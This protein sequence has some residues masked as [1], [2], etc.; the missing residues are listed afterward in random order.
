MQSGNAPLQ[1]GWGFVVR[2][3]VQTRFTAIAAWG[4]QGNDPAMAQHAFGQREDI[5]AQDKFLSATSALTRGFKVVF[6]G[7]WRHRGYMYLRPGGAGQWVPSERR[8]RT[9]KYSPFHE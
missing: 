6:H 5:D 2:N 4:L 3:V 1:P 7:V 9:A 8:S